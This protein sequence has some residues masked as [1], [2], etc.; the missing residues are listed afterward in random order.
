LY[1]VYCFFFTKFVIAFQDLDFETTAH[2]SLIRCLRFRHDFSAS[3]NSRILFRIYQEFHANSSNHLLNRKMIE[4][5][6]NQY[7]AGRSFESHSDFQNVS[8]NGLWFIFIAHANCCSHL[9]ILHLGGRH[10]CRTWYLHFSMTFS[11]LLFVL[12]FCFGQHK[13]LFSHNSVPSF[14]INCF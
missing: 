10:R 6:P 8:W 2:W 14:S 1:S 12:S 9:H 11:D 7:A 4:L 3:K 13:S 5:N